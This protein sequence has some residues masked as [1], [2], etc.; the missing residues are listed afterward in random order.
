MSLTDEAYVCVCECKVH[1]CVCV[2]ESEVRSR[3]SRG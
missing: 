3:L 2:G 1:V